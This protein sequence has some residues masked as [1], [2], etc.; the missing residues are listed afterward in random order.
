MTE[1]PQQELQNL[2]QHDKPAWL[3]DMERRRIV[4]A[5]DA[6]A[7]VGGEG[8]KFGLTTNEILE[9]ARRLY[10][11]AVRDM[12]LTEDPAAASRPLP[13]EAVAEI[14]GGE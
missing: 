6:A 14:D 10:D 3:W 8:A 2:R 11:A 4:W 1:G 7:A 13:G 9:V 5:T 12:G